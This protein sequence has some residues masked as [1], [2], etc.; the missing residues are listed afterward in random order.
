M[1]NLHEKVHIEQSSRY[2]A[3]KENVVY[4]LKKAN[5]GFK[6]SPRACFEKFSTVVAGIGFQRYQFDH[7]IFVQCTLLRLLF[8]PSMWMIFS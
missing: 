5:C 8:L 7:S 6:Q 4:K 2:G 3:Q 1:V